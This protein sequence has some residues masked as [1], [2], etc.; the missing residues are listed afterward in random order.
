MGPLKQP[1]QTK[2]SDGMH[3]QCRWQ[4]VYII[5]GA[6]TGKTT[7]ARRLA[8][9]LAVPLYELDNEQAS[10]RALS[11]PLPLADLALPFPTSSRAA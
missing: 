7:L 3:M 2:S 11:R 6:G 5:G 4:R 8:A 10:Q 9:R 1:W